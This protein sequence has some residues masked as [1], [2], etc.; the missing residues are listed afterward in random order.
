[1]QRVVLSNGRVVHVSTLS[2]SWPSV[3]RVRPPDSPAIFLE[4]DRSAGVDGCLLAGWALKRIPSFEFCLRDE[5]PG[6]LSASVS[7]Q[8][9][10]ALLRPRAQST[11]LKDVAH[12]SRVPS[13]II[14]RL[15]G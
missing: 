12:L 1:M 2:R 15:G 7:G 10:E 11:K 6:A 8:D 13:T 5:N 14:S 3:P 4:G 9:C